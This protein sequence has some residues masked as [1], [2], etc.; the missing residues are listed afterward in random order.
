MLLNVKKR[1]CESFTVFV[2][3][4]K[5]SGSWFYQTCT[6]FGFYQTAADNATES[7]FGN[8]FG[9]DFFIRQCSDVYGSEFNATSI[10]K[11]IQRTNTVYGGLQI[12]S[13]NVIYVHG[14]RDPWHLLGLFNSTDP[15]VPTIYIQGKPIKIASI[16]EIILLYF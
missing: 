13:T 4:E 15:K 16:N 9:V 3:L 5:I 2:K 8:H 7:V 10:A 1:V 14:S 6:E 12:H 11:A